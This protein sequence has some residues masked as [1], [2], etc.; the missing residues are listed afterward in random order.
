MLY[1][2][3]KD[4]W[5]RLLFET[6]VRNLGEWRISLSTIIKRFLDSKYSFWWLAIVMFGTLVSVL[7][8]VWMID[9]SI[10]IQH[11][12]E[13]M[14][15]LTSGTAILIGFAATCLTITR[16]YYVKKVG[17][18]LVLLTYLV[19]PVAFLFGAYIRLV[20]A[21]DFIEAI[22]AAMSSFG[23]SLALVF[24]VLFLAVKENW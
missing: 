22:R 1:C 24:L 11:I 4:Y 10:D 18:L 8:L 19:L 3:R 14:S 16:E 12:P 6:M 9:V 15:G 23:L 20:F 2:V 17:R 7:I 21:T 5:T 13:I